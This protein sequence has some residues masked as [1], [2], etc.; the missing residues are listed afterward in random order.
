[1]PGY[2]KALKPCLLHARMPWLLLTAAIVVL[3]ERRGWC[4]V[5]PLPL[6]YMILYIQQPSNATGSGP[7]NFVASH[8]LQR[9]SC[10]YSFYII[11][12]PSLFPLFFPFVF[13]FDHIFCL[14]CHFVGL[15][16]CVSPFF[17]Y[18]RRDGY[19]FY[20]RSCRPT[21]VALAAE[22]RE[23]TNAYRISGVD[24]TPAPVAVTAL[25]TTTAA[26]L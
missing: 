20:S 25:A 4:P 17:P 21:T 22:H 11:R 2:L 23:T 24:S 19:H 18:L 9:T 13:V 12:T 10:C 14:F 26:P 8:L 5:F 6:L 16:G 3:F 15:S 1:M 7:T